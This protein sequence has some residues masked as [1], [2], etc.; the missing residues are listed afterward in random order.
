MSERDEHE[1]IVKEVEAGTD[2]IT[3]PP[4]MLHETPEA[5]D[6]PVP[7]EPKARSLYGQILMMTVP[8]KIKLALKGNKDARAILMND[9]NKVIRRLVLQNP[10]ISEGEVAAIARNKNADEELLRM[11]SLR[12]D[13]LRHYPVRMG[14]I[15]NP[16]TPLPLA[17][18]ILPTLQQR[19]VHA[20]ARSRNVS[21]TIASQA[22]RLTQSK[23]DR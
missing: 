6:A 5:P 23:S 7:V 2:A 17:L 21:S 19:D 13:W 11:I 8:E 12:S 22:R 18:K 20:L 4:E 10:R 16:R 9:A 15:T 14:L 3:V 1:H